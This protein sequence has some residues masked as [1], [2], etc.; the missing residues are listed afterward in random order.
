MRRSG[1]FEFGRGRVP[2]NLGDDDRARMVAEAWARGEDARGFAMQWDA[3]YG[4]LRRVLESDARVR[5]ASL[6]VR[7]ESLCDTPADLLKAVADHCELPDA[8]SLIDRHAPGI[9]H[10]RYYEYDLSAADRAAIRAETA[11][12][13][14]HWGY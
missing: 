8:A 2:M 12:T 14:A 7:F 11:A 13:A 5:A 3:V 6:V 1:H 9:R 4:H 10:P